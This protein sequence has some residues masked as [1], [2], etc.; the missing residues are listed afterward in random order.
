MTVGKYASYPSLVDRTVFVPGGADGIGSAIVGN[1]A[2]QG[3]KA[4]VS[5]APRHLTDPVA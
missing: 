1:F 5:R 3:S 4:D 2:R